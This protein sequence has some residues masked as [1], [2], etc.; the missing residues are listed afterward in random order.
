MDEQKLPVSL[1]RLFTRIKQSFKS[2]KEEMLTGNEI[3]LL[4]TKALKEC[5]IKNLSNKFVIALTSFLE[6]IA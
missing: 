3:R 2:L 4:S 1:G 5:R 6:D